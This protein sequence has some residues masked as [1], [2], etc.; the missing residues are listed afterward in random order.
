MC[1][2]VLPVYIEVYLVYALPKEAKRVRDPLGLE[3]VT[4]F[5]GSSCR[6]W[7]PKLDPL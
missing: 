6:C 2:N 1:L 4:V 7:E 3:L 5:C